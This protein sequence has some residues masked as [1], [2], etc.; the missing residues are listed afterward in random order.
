MNRDENPFLP[1]MAAYDPFIEDSDSG[2]IPIAIVLI[3]YAAFWCAVGVA[4]GATFL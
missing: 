4:I 3:L 2:C 1:E